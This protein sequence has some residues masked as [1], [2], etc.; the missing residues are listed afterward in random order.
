MKVIKLIDKS[1]EVERLR[2]QLTSVTKE[3]A[4]L[5]GLYQTDKANLSGGQTGGRYHE[6]SPER[7]AGS[8]QQT[9]SGLCVFRL[10]RDYPR[11]NRCAAIDGYN[12]PRYIAGGIGYQEH[13]HTRHLV[14]LCRPPHGALLQHLFSNLGILEIVVGE[15]GPGQ[16]RRDGIDPYT[17]LCPLLRHYLGR[18]NY[19]GLAYGVSRQGIGAE[20]RH[21]GYIHDGAATLLLHNTRHFLAEKK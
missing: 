11:L 15:F 7:I 12:R 13:C 18:H 6:E 3:K 19:P 5:T 9:L 4:E 1:A 2:S 20:P 8:G 14:G 10:N 17:M 21:R 16:S